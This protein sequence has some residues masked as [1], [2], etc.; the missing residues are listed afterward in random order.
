MA[1]RD[2]SVETIEPSRDDDLVE[3]DQL[4]I[5][6][7]KLQIQLAVRMDERRLIW[8]RRLKKGDTT[9]AQLARAS[10]CHSMNVTQGIQPA[11]V[12]QARKRLTGK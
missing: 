3:L 7:E 4:S 8:D 1:R 6:I 9:K 11:L 5:A 10:K 12:E 2:I